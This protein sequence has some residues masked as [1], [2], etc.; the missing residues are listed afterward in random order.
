MILAL[1]LA[2]ASPV[3]ACAHPPLTPALRSS[4]SLAIRRGAGAA[5]PV[6]G[7]EISDVMDGGAWRL[8]WATPAESERGVYFLTRRGKGW[9][10]VDVWGGVI[11]PEERASTIAWARQRGPGVPA[12]LA[13]CFADALLAGN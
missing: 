12:T 13:A 3:A 2:S 9:K 4:M 6:R 5:Q 8:I 1:M 10:Y 11:A 7:S